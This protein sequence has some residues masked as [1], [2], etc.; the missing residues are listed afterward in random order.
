M[1]Q[2][3]HI[4]ADPIAHKAESIYYLTIYLKKK[5]QTRLTI[6]ALNP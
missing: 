5:N 1:A 3:W 6:L 2:S 4:A